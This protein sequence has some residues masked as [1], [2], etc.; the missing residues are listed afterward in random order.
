M[1][2]NEFRERE[3]AEQLARSLNEGVV[4]EVVALLQAKLASQDNTL[5][6][7]RGRAA[8]VLSTAALVVALGTGLGAIRFSAE[9]SGVQLDGYAAAVLLLLAIAIGVLT[10]IVQWPR[11]WIGGSGSD[12]YMSKL[13][14]DARRAA[15]ITMEQG[16]A[17][18]SVLLTQLFQLF[19]ASA[20]LLG[21]EVVVILGDVLIHLIFR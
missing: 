3:R 7:V 9:G 20:I 6:N 1:K 13:P 18:N 14:V 21:V 8:A 5:G 10:T 4:A 16:V 17:R 12:V 19:C 11:Q 15:I 2:Y